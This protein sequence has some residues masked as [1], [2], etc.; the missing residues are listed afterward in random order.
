MLIEP[1][2][3]VIAAALKH[4]PRSWL[5][6]ASR[7]LIIFPAIPGLTPQALRCRPLRG[8]SVGLATENRQRPQVVIVRVFPSELRRHVHNSRE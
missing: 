6:P 7:A 3:R 2:K 8:L 4:Q 1:A 5:P